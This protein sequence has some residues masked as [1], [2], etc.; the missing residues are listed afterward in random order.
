MSTDLSNALGYAWIAF[1]LIAFLTMAPG[2]ARLLRNAWKSHA[3]KAMLKKVVNV[4]PRRNPEWP[5]NTKEADMIA[6][7]ALLG[8]IFFLGLL[9][10]ALCSR[11]S[12]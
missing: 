9:T 3:R 1:G 8:F 10:L 6:F 2:F 7:C 12:N 4:S 5:N 11:S